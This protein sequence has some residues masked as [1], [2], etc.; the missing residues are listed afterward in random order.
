[1]STKMPFPCNSSITCADP[2]PLTCPISQ[3]FL[4]LLMLMLQKEPELRPSAEEILDSDV[5]ESLG[6]SFLNRRELLMT[7]DSMLE[8]EE[9]G[10]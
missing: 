3:Q 8:G 4:T 5:I 10:L 1:M 2:D 6:M 9:E 7:N